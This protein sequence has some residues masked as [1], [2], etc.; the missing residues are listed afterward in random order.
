MCKVTNYLLF[1]FK[2][3]H[4][5]R[6]I[7]IRRTPFPLFAL[8]SVV[9]SF[10][11][12]SCQREGLDYPNGQA[13]IVVSSPDGELT[14]LE[15][16]YE[17]TLNKGRMTVR[18][19]DFRAE[20]AVFHI[21]DKW[22]GSNG[23]ITLNRHL[24]VEGD[25]QGAGFYS[26]EVFH[27]AVASSWEESLF[28][29]PGTIYG[30]PHTTEY[31]K[32]GTNYYNAGF[33]SLREDYLPAPLAAVAE[34]EGKWAAILNTCPNG[35][36]TQQE[37]SA[38]AAD[39]IVD[40]KLAFGA[41]DI[42][43]GEQGVDLVYRF[44]GS[45]EEFSGRGAFS[46]SSTT[47]ESMIRGRFHPVQD[48]FTQDYT[49]AFKTGLSPSFPQVEREVWRWTWSHLDPKVEPVDVEMV[50]NTLLDHLDERLVT[51]E[52]RISFFSI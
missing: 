2:L 33:F 15:P 5:I 6:L 1:L 32:G 36:T 37:T 42:R 11:C 45:D 4:M 10:A 46:I 16:V 20:G 25:Y 47:P 3:T 41:L 39:R 22:T 13:A 31:S 49:V 35:Y 30:K 52:G 19:I 27:G 18:K 38:G 40:G 12:I 34:P 8:I 44:P 48:G 26:E 24:E 14:A 7:S 17:K 51:Y 9:F 43:K 21:I 28:M 50:K 29:I 23:E